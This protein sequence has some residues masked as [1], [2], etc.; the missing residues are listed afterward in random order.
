MMTRN[1]KLS[2]WELTLIAEALL[3]SALEYQ[4]NAQT[5]RVAGVCG[6]ADALE[7]VAKQILDLSKRVVQNL[8]EKEDPE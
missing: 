6:G 7:N 8:E 2:D 4:K 5:L 3:T 1:M